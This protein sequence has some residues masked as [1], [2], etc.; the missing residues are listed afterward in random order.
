MELAKKIHGE[1]INADSMQVYSD[2]E[3]LTSRPSKD[4]IKFVP[5][6]L[7]GYIKA[8]TRYNVARWCN[9]IY[10]IINNNN[11]KNIHSIIVGGTGMY[12]DK[13][14]NGLIQM[15]PIPEKVKKESAILL[16]KE[17]IDKFADKVRNIDDKALNKIS[18]NDTNRLRRIWEVYKHTNQTL[19]YW[20]DN[21]NKKFLFNQ[22]YLI[23]LFTPNRKEIYHKVNKR[24]IKMINTGAIDEVK[25]L[26]KLN[27]DN[28]LPIMRA[29]GV[30]EIIN[31]LSDSISIDE[32]INK[33]QQITRN[34]V[35][36]QLTWWRSST[37]RIHECINQ[38]PSEININS[39][40]FS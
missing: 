24:F 39:L 15:P 37:L 4:D 7:Y 35:K 36:R 6:H 10:K 31:Y 14:V 30:P 11:N 17:G 25:K 18:K 12:I 29:H 2:L 27:L 9:D 28:S 23:Y 3:I 26:K 21:K 38:F 16:S 34:Y 33:G 32:C 13:L 8:S 1:I 22:E 20:L 19:T 5:H 40:N